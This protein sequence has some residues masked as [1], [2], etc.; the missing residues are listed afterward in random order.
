MRYPSRD[1]AERQEVNGMALTRD[2]RETIVERV[3]RD[4]DFA[5]APLDETATLFLN[6]EADTARL[7]LRVLINSTVGSRRSPWQR[8]SRRRACDA[9]ARCRGGL[10]LTRPWTCGRLQK[11]VQPDQSAELTSGDSAQR[12]EVVGTRLACPKNIRSDQD[13]L[14][15]R[16]IAHASFE[17]E[18]NRRRTTIRRVGP[19]TVILCFVG[20]VTDGFAHNCRRAGVTC[21]GTGSGNSKSLHLNSRQIAVLSHNPFNDLAVSEDSEPLA[22]GARRSLMSVSGGSRHSPFTA[23]RHPAKLTEVIRNRKQAG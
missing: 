10:S 2:F 18:P 21:G 15:A 22:S 7:V 6:G 16:R 14:P 12:P 11:T 19:P 5:R 17:E 20:Q 1:A 4:P 8:R 23:L 13:F 9:G 3:R